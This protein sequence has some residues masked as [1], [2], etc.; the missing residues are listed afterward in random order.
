MRTYAGIIGLV[1]A[2]TLIPSTDAVPPEGKPATRLPNVD[3]SVLPAGQFTGTLVSPPDSN[4]MFTLTITYPEVR[5]KAGVKTP[6][7]QTAQGQSLLRQYQ[8]MMN[9]QQQIGRRNAQ[10]ALLNMMQMHQ[11]CTQLQM[12]SQRSMQA[13]TRLQQQQLQREL[14]LLQQE[15]KAIQSLY[16]VVQVKRD[17]DFQAEEKIKVRLKNPPEQFDEKGFV[18]KYSPAELSELKGKDKSL[19][20]Y[21]SSGEALKPGQTVLVNLRAHKPAKSTTAPTPAAKKDKDAE[22]KETDSAVAHKM[23][24]TMIVILQDG[25]AASDSTRQP[26]KN[27]K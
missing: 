27:K 14:R 19:I 7:L 21:E 15:I 16:Q 9:L 23:Q 1:S 13:T 25:D 6:N 2:L 4:R 11:R 5:Q 8:Q 17:F 12:T 18:K 10:Q 26:K 24:A 20:G 3:A 22:K